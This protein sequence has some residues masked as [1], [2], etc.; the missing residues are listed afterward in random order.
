MKHKILMIA[1]VIGTLLNFSTEKVYAE[2]N[3]S[4]QFEEYKDE[5][6]KII[7]NQVKIQVDSL[8]EGTINDIE[9][10]NTM[11]ITYINIVLSIISLAVAVWAAL[12]IINAINSRKV[13]QLEKS[14]KI[15]KTKIENLNHIHT[16]YINKSKVQEKNIVTLSIFALP[17]GVK[18]IF[19]YIL[20]NRL[21]SFISYTDIDEQI[22]SISPIYKSPML[23]EKVDSGVNR[24][25][26]MKSL[27]IVFPFLTIIDTGNGFIFSIKDEEYKNL[28]QSV[29]AE[30]TEKSLNTDYLSGNIG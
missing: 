18:K 14:Y 2:E 27:K 9:K 23:K 4:K 5:V 10:K 16:D 13:N 12:G 30:L 24:S 26:V 15:L 11:L 29:C 22:T 28:Y 3:I 17:L 20:N 1:I 21:D 7:E 8:K 6:N 19:L 25:R